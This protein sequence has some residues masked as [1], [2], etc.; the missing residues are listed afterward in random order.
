MVILIFINIIF[1]M[2]VNIDISQI[3]KVVQM[4]VEE[5]G[6]ESVVI[7]PDQYINFL[8]FTNYNGKL[9]Q[10]MKQFRGKRIVINGDLSL[11]NTDANNIT[12]IT[13]NGG[14]DLSYTQVNSLEGLIYNNISYYATPYEKIQIKKQRQ[15]ELAKQ[16]DLR[17]E[18]EWNLET[19]TSDIAILA[20]VLFE[21]LTSSSGFYEAKEPG[22]DA[23]LQQ[24]YA[25]KERREQIE[26]ETEDDENLTALRE[27]DAEIEEIEG[28]IDIY[29][30]IYEGKHYFLHSFK[31]LEHHGESRATW[32]VGDEYDTEKTAFQTV[33]N[34]IDDVGLD[35]FR[36][37]FVENHIDEEE[38]KAKGIVFKQIPYEIKIY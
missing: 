4:L 8:K 1:I 34:L 37:G 19:A 30:I 36:T 6:Q 20:N 9:V 17:Q 32:A 11:R 15:I 14:L 25:E 31:V 33:E 18:D 7:T 29:D 13:V 10:N 22:D 35:G 3:Q 21:F 16:N 26:K 5:E 38:L 23:R 2:R 12:N 24:L 27:I 28:R